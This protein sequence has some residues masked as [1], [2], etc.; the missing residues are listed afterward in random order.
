LTPCASKRT[1]K[2]HA[3][4]QSRRGRTRL[5]AL[6]V[7]LGGTSFAKP[8]VK[9][10]AVAV[11]LARKA[12][13]RANLA[14]S[15]AKGAAATGGPKGDA[16]PQGPVGPQGTTGQRG[17]AG[18]PGK[19]GTPGTDGTP[20]KDG[21]PG[22]DATK[23]FASVRENGTILEQSGGV[24][25][26]RFGN[27]TGGTAKGA[28]GVQFPG[29]VTHCVPVASIGEGTGNTLPAGQATARTDGHANGSPAASFVDVVTFDS[30]GAAADLPFNLVLAC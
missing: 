20:G 1:E 16:G 26:I 25:V 4:P 29:D 8:S 7:A 19:D 22:K 28:Y 10:S 21:A 15:T 18:L 30:A 5:V 27:S 2:T 17:P 3:S 14:L 24:S 12:L 6:F 13:K 11:G 23:L 9:G